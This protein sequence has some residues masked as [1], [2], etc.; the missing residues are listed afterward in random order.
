VMGR[1]N[2]VRGDIGS[3]VMGSVDH[4]AAARVD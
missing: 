3:L 1:V 4:L 2:D